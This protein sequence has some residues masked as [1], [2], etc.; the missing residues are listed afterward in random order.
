MPKA[1]TTYHLAWLSI[2]FHR[3]EEWLASRLRDGFDVHHLD[4]DHGN[5]V[6]E[7]LVLIECT[8]HM[9]IHGGGG[10]RLLV[11]TKGARKRPPRIKP[12]REWLAPCFGE[13]EF[14]PSK[15]R[16]ARAARIAARAERVEAD[17]K[18][19]MQEAIA[20]YSGS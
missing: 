13:V 4:G 7:N 12:K 20:A 10:N 18:I 5:N 8:D 2:H 16:L 11:G 9:R 15:A 19:R 3:N 6:P 17:N 1:L 14:V